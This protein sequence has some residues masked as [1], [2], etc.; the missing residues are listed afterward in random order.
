MY[1]LA[2][3]A[4]R[5]PVAVT[6]LAAAVVVLG[7]IQR[8]K[9]LVQVLHRFGIDQRDDGLQSPVLVGRDEAVVVAVQP[10]KDLGDLGAS[11][12]LLHSR[13]DGAADRFGLVQPSVLVVVQ[14]H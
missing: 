1:A 10:A 7:C 3:Y 5:R 13:F 4:T 14:R 2:S 6:V 8:A 11:A 9:Q 12:A